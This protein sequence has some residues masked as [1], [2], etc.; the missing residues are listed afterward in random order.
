M[1]LNKMV[2]TIITLSVVIISVAAI[3][4]PVLN[5]ATQTT[6]TLS[7]ASGDELGQLIAIDSTTEYEMTWDVTTPG[8]ATVN[9]SEIDLYSGTLIC[10]GDPDFLIRYYSGSTSYM[11]GRDGTPANGFT[12][13]S[14]LSITIAEGSATIVAD[15]DSYTYTITEGFALADSGEYV[16]KSSTQS[17]YMLA[18]SEFYAYG[19]SSTDGSTLWM[20]ISGTIEDGATTTIISGP[21]GTFSD[22]VVDATE[23][24]GYV[25]TYALD[26]ITLTFT[27]S[28]TSVD[29]A[30][31]YNYF[32]VPASVTAE[33][34][35]HL[36]SG[37]I[38]LLNAIPA[39]VLVC[40]VMVAVGLSASKRDD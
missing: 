22:I 33:L 17:A 40:L 10:G 39:L 23:V 9:G 26:K 5:N 8:V 25:D 19:V 32:I 13:D 15:G 11:Q 30:L 14:T 18:D 31:T 36:T 6:A 29:T 34:P 12:A 4:M 35:Q 1:E 27:N 37:E 3:M 28:S 20:T 21:E 24:D 7:N 16:M 38:A 2:Y